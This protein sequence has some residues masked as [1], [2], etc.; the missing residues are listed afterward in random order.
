[1]AAV[2]TGIPIS[3]VLVGVTIMVGLIGIIYR[4]LSK[5]LDLAMA[6][7]G[8]TDTKN[9]L[10]FKEVR[11]EMK[12]ASTNVNTACK[13]VRSEMKEIEEKTPDK[14]T[15]ILCSK[16][17]EEKF[18]NINNR[19]DELKTI[20]RENHTALVSTL[21]ELHSSVNSI[22]ACVIKLSTD[23]PCLTGEHR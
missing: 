14:D 9:V 20:H 23:A 4:N 17:A 8:K 10:E 21:G 12:E 13:E 18:Q 15:C 22:N 11:K 7:V 19:I 6:A 5:S 1:M 2:H 16:L 3:Y